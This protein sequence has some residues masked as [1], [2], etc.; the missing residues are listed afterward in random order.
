MPLQYDISQNYALKSTIEQLFGK[1]A[2]LDLKETTSLTI[3]RAYVVKIFN[4]IEI[5]I[6]ES[7]AIRDDAWINEISENLERGRNLAKLAKDIE[8]LVSI[9]AAVLLRQVFLQIGQCPSR[10]SGKKVTLSR[11]NW[12]LNE[13]RS[14]QYVQSPIQIEAVFWGEQQRR[15]GIERQMYLRTQYRKSKSRLP[16]S[17]WCLEFE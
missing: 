2:W 7:V 17:K 11:E 4:A 16:F 12:R 14:V 1:Q 3:W 9:L 10:I 13:S 5:S 15:I 8:T 6:H